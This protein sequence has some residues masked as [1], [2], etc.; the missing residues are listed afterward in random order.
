MLGIAPQVYYAHTVDAVTLTHL[1]GGVAK[2]TVYGALVGG[3]GCLAGLRSGASAAAV[4]KAATSAV[5][6][7]MVLVIAA[8][9]VFAVLFYLMGV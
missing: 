9:G 6:S 8:C 4:G 1:V 5:V 2:A 7:G 3:A